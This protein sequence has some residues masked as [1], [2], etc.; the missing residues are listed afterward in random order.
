MQSSGRVRRDRAAGD[1]RLRAFARE[2]LELCR[3]KSAADDVALGLIAAAVADESQLLF[4]FDALGHDVESE[5]G[6]ES[7]QRRYDACVGLVIG[8]GA[9]PCTG[10]A[11]R[12]PGPSR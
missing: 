3:W 7:D 4:G 1:L 2:L 12:R 8:C 5:A 6:C 9:R 11:N 10:A